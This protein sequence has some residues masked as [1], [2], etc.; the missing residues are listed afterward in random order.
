MSTAAELP[1]EF[2]VLYQSPL[3]SVHDYVCRA[4]R[5]GPEAEEYSDENSI[6]LM[7][8]GQFCKHFGRRGVTADVNQSVFSSRRARPTA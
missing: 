8:S 7:R 6:V 5:G 1:L 3:V 2:R 4:C